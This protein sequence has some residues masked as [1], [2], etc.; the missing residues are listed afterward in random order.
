MSL[1]AG[2]RLD[3]YEIVGPLAAGGMGEVW[4]AKDLR[5]QR[6]VAIKILP[7]ELTRQ[8]ARVAR[9]EREARAA[10]ALNHPN[11]CTIYAVGETP[12]GRHFI[13]MEL[14][15]GVTLR[16][17]LGS[18]RLRPLEAIDVAIQIAS[19]LTAA[20][21]AGIVHRDIKPE[22]II[23]RPDRIVKVLDFG[24]AK[25]TAP[26]P[27]EVAPTRTQLD[28]HIGAIVGTVAYMS[29]EQ[30]RGEP[31][32][33]RTDI[34]SLAVVLYELLAGRLPFAGRS[35]SD[36][37]A[38]I[39]EHD[40]APLAPVAPDLPPELHRIIAKALKKDCDRRYQGMKDLQVDLE[41]VRD[42]LSIA[43]TTRASTPDGARSAMLQPALHRRKLPIPLAVLLAVAVL[44]AGAGW[45]M[46][47]LIARNQPTPQRVSR[48]LRR[49]T[50]DAGLQT[51]VT[52]SPGARSIAYASDK[53]GNFDIWVQRVEGGDALQIT[54]SPA[55]DT[56]PT[57]S[58]DD[59]TIVF[60]SERDRGGLFVVP[61]S[62]GA[63]RRLT[64]FGVRPR[65]APDGSQLL[66]AA[67][68]VLA[69]GIAS[70]LYTVRLDGGS[71]Q[72]VLE[73]FF[74]QL[75]R[76]LGGMRDWNWYPDSR[77]VSILG[78]VP[79]QGFG[80][81]TVPL[82]GGRAMFLKGTPELGQW[83]AFGWASPTTLFVECDNDGVHRVVKFTV[84]P[85]TMTVVA[86]EP[87]TIGDGWQS[88]FALSNDG[89]H[90][91]FTMTTMSQRL[92]SVPFDVATGQTS[93]EG[94]PV[95]DS[96][97]LATTSDLS[98]DGTRLAYTLAMAGT[99]RTKL[100]MTD[101]ATTQGRALASDDQRR[102]FPQ[103]SPDGTRLA[104]RWVRKLGDGASESGLAV[105]RADTGE[106]ELISTPRTDTFVTPWDWSPE[107]ERVIVSSGPLP[108]SGKASLGLWPL[109][110]APH[111]E[112]A[113]KVLAADDNYAIWQARFSPDRRWIC[114]AAVDAR[115]SGID[116]IFVIPSAG[117]DRSRWTA[118]TSGHGWADKPRWSPD[119][120]MVYF[121]QADSFLNV[122]AVR[123]DGATG[124]AI[125]A[126]FQVTRYDS[127]RH[128]LSPSFEAAEIG[129]S[130][131]RL[132][133]TIM[134]QSGN[135]WTMDNV[136]K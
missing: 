85:K 35:A 105:R 70:P 76:A 28:S 127:P 50:F 6:K 4:I 72:P 66:F 41:G 19:A 111:A 110:A 116:T 54:N 7:T 63:E 133:L 102:E 34:W 98:R 94:Q 49:V 71:P 121:V 104:Y 45:A 120:K 30:A 16:Q 124:T 33:G 37:I 59:R 69:A 68:D 82:S 108:F 26:G 13:A 113:V 77:H 100:W 97:G 115:E 36:L 73:T 62:G 40:A 10:S 51:D 109:A 107:G 128:Q 80:L 44:G 46:R 83:T 67:A 53:S 20:H 78:I 106:E 31:V 39:L 25:L 52:W 32:D 118:L 56:Q 55:Q 90:L 11:V 29:P 61:A 74:K 95:S 101:L 2:D 24:L 27:D 15:E 135:V 47:D 48:S 60:R 58:P 81:Y 130:A 84:D 112:T 92:W 123:F 1:A 21:N 131:Q 79:G 136:D 23:L 122:W 42:D 99:D 103:W 12:D 129:V 93:G 126:P 96:M 91:A 132:I 117:A 114:F 3:A 87:V 43:T 18:G 9:F 38:A 119:G 57:W 14:V 125:G 65:W 64:S 17:R 75:S 8:P 134:E 88:R 5:L 89:R 22:N 86:T